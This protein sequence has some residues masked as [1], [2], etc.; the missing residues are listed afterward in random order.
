MTMCIAKWPMCRGACFN[1]CWWRFR[2][3]G[4]QFGR[5]FPRCALNFTELPC[6][7]TLQLISKRGLASRADKL[8][9]LKKPVEDAELIAIFLK[10]LVPVFNQ[11][12]VAFAI[13]GSMPKKF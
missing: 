12:Q 1:R 5:R 8:E 10:G 6:K 7:K 11:L 9:F 2:T 3:C 13:P 4:Q